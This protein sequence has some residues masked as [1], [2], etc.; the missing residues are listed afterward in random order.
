MLNEFR[1]D[2]FKSLI[3]VTFKPKDLNLLLGLN[4]SGKT[5]LCQAMRFVSA[6]VSLPLNKCAVSVAGQ[7]SRIPN[8]FFN[9]RT[10]D[11][12]IKANLPLETGN[13]AFR[14]ELTISTPTTSSSEAGLQVEREQLTVTGMEFNDTLLLENV[15]GKV[16]L[17]DEAK[18]L[19]GDT[20]YS[21]TKVTRDATMLSRI[22]DLN[23]NF[24]LG[25]FMHYLASWRYYDLSP[26]AIRQSSYKPYETVLDSQGHNLASVL[27]HLK[28]SN[29]RLYRELLKSAQ[30][31]DP[32]ISLINFLPTESNV[33]MVFED[34]NGHPLTMSNISNGTLRFISL[35][36]VLRVQPRLPRTPLIIIE[37]PENGIYVGF[38]KELIE[39]AAQ[40]P[41]SPQMIFTSHS[42]YFIDLFDDRLDSIF[43]LKRDAQHSA[44]SQPDIERVT[45]RLEDFPL[46]EQHFRGMLS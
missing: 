17:L 22:Y 25:L 44:I 23:S 39:M 1:V 29:E 21:E 45:A 9:K 13:L 18:Y 4:N 33:F 34:E 26:V 36:Y 28:T 15:Q 41:E 30:K 11:F 10:T 32:S 3:N 40:S 20:Q 27:Y 24:R 7:L 8:H 12:H 37:E 16:R 38:L 5:N 14:Y 31:F 35:A 46:G 19:I 2:N 6:S 43:I 42:P